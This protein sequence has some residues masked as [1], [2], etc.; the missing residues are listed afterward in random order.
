MSI[1]RKSNNDEPS[2]MPNLFEHCRGE[3]VIAGLRSNT[4]QYYIITKAG[5]DKKSVPVFFMSAKTFF[6]TVVA[7]RIMSC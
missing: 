2:A 7:K 4:E 6:G 5:A 3:E 1:S